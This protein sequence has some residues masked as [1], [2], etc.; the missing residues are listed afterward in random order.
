MFDAIHS[1]RA[2]ASVGRPPPRTIVGGRHDDIAAGTSS[3]NDIIAT[4]VP[5]DRIEA[6]L[7]SDPC[8]A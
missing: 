8:L 4:D 7:T 1:I 2:P 5:D 6:I 3:L